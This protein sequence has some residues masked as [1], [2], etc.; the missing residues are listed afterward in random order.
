MAG[1]RADRSGSKIG[2]MSLIAAPLGLLLGWIVLMLRYEQGPNPGWFVSHILLLTGAILFIPAVTGLKKLAGRDAVVISTIATGLALAGAVILAGQFMIDLAVASV[3]STSAE[4]SALLRQVSATSGVGLLFYLIG[5]IA[6][7]SGLIMLVVTLL[8]HHRIPYW[9][10][11]LL[12]IGIVAVTGQAL[13]GNAAITLL[14]FA[15]M[16]FGFAPVG[17]SVFEGA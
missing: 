6:F 12:I 11:A 17:R 15:L 1:M 8:T 5:P 9:I 13:I 16:T 7:Y 4:M 2:G 10:G 14:G 3:S